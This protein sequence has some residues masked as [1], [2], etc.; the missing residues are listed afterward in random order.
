MKIS[1]VLVL[2]VLC[3]ACSSKHESGAEGLSLSATADS[4]AAAFAAD[5]TWHIYLDSTL[6]RVFSIELEERLVA[7]RK[8]IVALL[9][10][11][12]IRRTS[13][14]INGLFEPSV[15][16]PWGMKVFFDLRLSAEQVAFFLEGPREQF[17]STVIAVAQIDSVA[18]PLLGMSSSADQYG[19]VT[20]EPE[21]PSYAVARGRLIHALIR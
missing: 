12:D 4:L 18:K 5:R 17:L 13:D 7:T 6:N 14:G 15:F 2:S 8:P 9:E 3:I 19:V 10:L 1:A 21:I 16:G 20:N 11:A